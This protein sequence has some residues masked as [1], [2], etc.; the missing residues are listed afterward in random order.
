MITE[1]AMSP[2]RL[3]FLGTT[4]LSITLRAFKYFNMFFNI[5]KARILSF[6]IDSEL[7]E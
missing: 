2:S 6:L 7:F 4:Y 1:P 5:L 3:L